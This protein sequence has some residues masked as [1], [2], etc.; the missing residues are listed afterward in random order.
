MNTSAAL[1]GARRVRS[2]RRRARRRGVA[3]WHGHG[4]RRPPEVGHELPQDSVRSTAA[5]DVRGLRARDPVVAA[6]RG[7]SIRARRCTVVTA[8]VAST[9]STLRARSSSPRGPSSTGSAASRRGRPTSPARPAA[10]AVVFARCDIGSLPARAAR[11]TTSCARYEGHSRAVRAHAAARPAHALVAIDIESGAAAAAALV[12]DKPLR[13]D[14]SPARAAAAARGSSPRSA[15]RSASAS[16]RRP[17]T[18]PRLAA[19]VASRLRRTVAEDMVAHVADGADGA[20]VGASRSTRAPTRAR[21]LFADAARLDRARGPGAR[22][23]ADASAAALGA[24]ARGVAHPSAVVS[25]VPPPRAR[26]VRRNRRAHAGVL[27]KL[28]LLVIGAPAF[29]SRLSGRAY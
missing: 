12:R 11:A 8:R 6:G 22:L 5:L 10:S 27:E 25:R 9:R 2:S 7:R 20:E 17:R 29:L 23:R 1:S 24:A 13:V 15:R 28:L 19:E 16:P 4:A 26:A 3:R 14:V 21:A 18:A